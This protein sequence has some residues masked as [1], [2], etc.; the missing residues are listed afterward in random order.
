[1][2]HARDYTWKAWQLADGSWQRL[3]GSIFVVS[4]VRLFYCSPAL[5]PLGFM[6]WFFDPSLQRN[7]LQELMADWV[8]GTIDQ[9]PVEACA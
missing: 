9:A 3:F 2:T 8:A 5:V 1:L 7:V 4:P 6:A